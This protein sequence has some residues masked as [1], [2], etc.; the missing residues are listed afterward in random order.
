[1]GKNHRTADLVFY[2]IGQ[3]GT[4]PIKILQDKFYPTLFFGHFDW[5]EKKFNQSKCLKKE[6]SIKFT[7]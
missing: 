3:A 4:G 6:H 1:M 7:L 2:R 5:M